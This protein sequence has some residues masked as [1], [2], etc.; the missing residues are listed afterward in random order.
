ME[1]YHMWPFVS[2]FF[3]LTLCLTLAVLYFFLLPNTILLY[4]YAIFCLSIH[5]FM[6]IRSFLFFWYY[7]WYCYK[8]LYTTFHMN[9]YIFNSLEY[10]PRSEN[11]GSYVNC[12]FNILKSFQTVFHSVYTIFHSG[13]ECVKVLMFLHP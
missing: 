4:G 9:I 11:A 5:Q 6:G 10:K 7:E 12:I 1:S 2:S 13:Q 8:H 3:H